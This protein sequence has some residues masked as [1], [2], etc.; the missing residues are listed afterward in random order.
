MSNYPIG[1]YPSTFQRMGPYPNQGYQPRPNTYRPAPAPYRPYQPMPTPMPGRDYPSYPR[2]GPN[3]GG[4]VGDVWNGVKE[5]TFEVGQIIQ[6]PLNKFARQTHSRNPYM[7]VSTGETVGRWVVNGALIAGAFV[8]G[9]AVLGGGL[10]GGGARVGSSF[11]L[12]NILGGVTDA[13]GGVVGFV[14]RAIGGVFKFA[15][16]AIG[17]VLGGLKDL[18]AGL[19]GMGGAG[20]GF[21]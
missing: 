15:F 6:H 10:G 21:R 7:P 19:F 13:I 20:V 4:F 17:W 12:G 2:Q 14:F 9:K 11:S 5:R 1:N 18:V 8:A 3:V 16:N